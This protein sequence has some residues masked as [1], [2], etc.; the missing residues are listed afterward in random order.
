MQAPIGKVAMLGTDTTQDHPSLHV[1]D[2]E[3]VD[4]DASPVDEVGKCSGRNKGR[5]V[6]AAHARLDLAAGAHS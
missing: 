4:D 1:L 3:A 2:P 5:S 6:V